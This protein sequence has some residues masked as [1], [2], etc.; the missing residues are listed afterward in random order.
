MKLYLAAFDDGRGWQ[1]M[2]RARSAETQRLCV[3]GTYDS[4]IKAIRN[5]KY[6]YKPETDFKVV[7]FK[8][9]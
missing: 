3:Y 4:A 7:E 6:R 8:E 9:A 5:V 1:P 2:K